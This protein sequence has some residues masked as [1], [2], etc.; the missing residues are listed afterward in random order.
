MAEETTSILVGKRVS[1][2]FRGLLHVPRSLTNINTKSIV[3]DGAGS[4]TS[5]AV[6]YSGYGVDI[7]GDLNITNSLIVSGGFTVQGDFNTSS[8]INFLTGGKIND[9]YINPTNSAY[10][11]C[12]VSGIGA[13]SFAILSS[14]ND[15]ELNFS[16]SKIY[17]IY[18]KKSLPNNLYIKPQA[19]TENESPFW[20]D[21]VNNEVNIRNLR[22]SNIKTNTTTGTPNK[23]DLYRN[24]V[25]VGC[26]MMFPSLTVPA[27]WF[28]CNGFQYDTNEYAELFA[29]VGYTYGTGTGTNFRIPDLRGLFVRGLDTG[30]L[31]N[32]GRSLGNVEQ[33]LIK[34]HIHESTGNKPLLFDAGTTVPQYTNANAPVPSFGT[35]NSDALLQGNNVGGGNETRPKNLALVYCIKW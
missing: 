5:L 9:L 16:D 31:I 29:V 26:I 14:P 22:I 4:P 7:T 12:A 24:V 23:T 27:G 11:L 18:V 34:T 28:E 10:S 21:T 2:T 33:D 35:V 25:P 15:Y 32:P 13:T 1:T 6:S 30:G 8:N 17:S 19:K 20:I 3:Y